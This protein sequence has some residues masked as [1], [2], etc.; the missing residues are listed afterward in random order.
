MVNDLE[1][2]TQN[3]PGRNIMEKDNYPLRSM[4][5]FPFTHGFTGL[6]TYP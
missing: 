1:N 4:L 3:I 5:T 2:I 6:Q